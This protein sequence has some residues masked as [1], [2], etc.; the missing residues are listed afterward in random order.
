MSILNNLNPKQKK[1]ALKIEGASLILAGAGSGKT[2]T[3]TYKIAYMVKEK[4]INPNNVLALTFTN[5]AAN[6]MKERVNSLIGVNSAYMNISTFHS[7]AVR[8]LRQYGENIGFNSKFNIYDTDDSQSL[9]RKI[10]KKLILRYDLTPKTYLNK[11]SKLKE[12]EILPND[13]S[14]H[15]NLNMPENKEFY[16]VY[17]LY[18]D[19]LIKNNSMD[20]SDILYYCKKLLLNDRVLSLVQ[21][22]YKYI[23]VDEYQDTNK[24]QYDIINLISKKYGNICVVGDEDQSIYAF[25]GAD[26][27]NILNFEKDYPDAL[28]IKLEQ[29]YRSTPNILGLANSVIVKNTTSLGKKLWTKNPEGKKI[30][31]FDAE[32][33]YQE[34]KYICSTI[35]NSGKKYNNFAILYRTNFQSRI[36]EQELTRNNIP[37]MVYGGISFYQRKEIKDLLAYLVLINN[38]NDTINFERAITNPK[39]KIGAVT[40]SKI[41]DYGAKNNLNCVDALICDTSQKVK[42]FYELMIYLRKFSEVNKV[43]DLIKE[44]LDKTNYTLSLEKLENYNDKLLN[45]QELYNAIIEIEKIDENITL[46]E[47][48]TTVSLSSNIDNLDSSNVVKLMTIHNSKGLEF[49]TVFLTGFEYGLFPSFKSTFDNNELEEERRLCYVAITRA[50]KELH[51]TYAKS[52]MING[53]TKYGQVPSDFYSD[54]DKKFL[55]MV[56]KQKNFVE[57][58]QEKVRTNIENFNPFKIKT[59]NSRYNIGDIVN[60]TIFGK[61]KIKHIDERALTI[62]FIVGE[63]KIALLLADKFLK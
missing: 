41:I 7:F 60:H 50:K 28:I 6:E 59:N 36:L 20:F 35:K 55:Y 51:I 45:I 57:N 40:I 12:D 37:N 32:D 61:G 56:N 52:R 33:A 30:L 8:L 4:G 21:D 2:R 5:K 54:M 16:D 26:I 17:K 10:M 43:S 53:V 63:K 18:Q 1:A 29:N 31:F 14:K 27:N 22:K 48:L 44:I 42:D 9:I 3:I 49:D 13:L 23:L 24:L 58:K 11:I 19:E 62:E 39:R 25:R 38:P 47:Y 34:A 46:D 15:I